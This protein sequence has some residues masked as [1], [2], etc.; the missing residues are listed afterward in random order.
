M[1]TSV[2]WDEFIAS[3]QRYHAHMQCVL[4]LTHLC[5]HVSDD[6]SPR[7]ETCHFTSCQ[8]ILPSFQ[9]FGTNRPSALCFHIQIWNLLCCESSEG[10]KY[11]VTRPCSLVMEMEEISWI[12]NINVSQALRG[13]WPA[14]SLS[15][16]QFSL[17]PRITGCQSHTPFIFQ[18]P[19]LLSLPFFPCES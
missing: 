10:M 13:L 17:I 2:V 14:D 6:Q 5:E 7:T 12:F 8:L 9:V 18:S 11:S 16:I 4:K 19:F 15:L 3:R 1:L